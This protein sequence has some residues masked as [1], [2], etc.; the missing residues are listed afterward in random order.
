MK[1]IKRLSREQMK[2]PPTKV[3]PK[4]K[5]KEPTRE[6]LLMEMLDFD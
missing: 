2:V 6:E 4:Y 1:E 5:K 3:K